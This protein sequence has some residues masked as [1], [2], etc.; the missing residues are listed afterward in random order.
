[1]S[2]RIRSNPYQVDQSATGVGKVV[3][4][5]KI[6]IRFSFG[7]ANEGALESGMKGV[8]CRGHEHVVT[9]FWSLTSGKIIID[10]DGREIHFSCQK[11]G[12]F[13]HSWSLKVNHTIEVIAHAAPAST[14]IDARPGW[15][16]YDLTIN[17]ISY[18][19]LPKIFELGNIP[20]Q[21]LPAMPCPYASPTGHWN[22]SLGQEAPDYAFCGSPGL[23]P[24]S[25][26]EG[27]LLKFSEPTPAPIQ[28]H[29][30][31]GLPPTPFPVQRAYDPSGSDT[32]PLAFATPLAGGQEAVPVL[33]TVPA[34]ISLP[35]S[36]NKVHAPSPLAIEDRR[37][38]GAMS[39]VER[40]LDSLVNLNDITSPVS[41]QIGRLT[42]MQS[43]DEKKKKTTSV[44]NVKPLATLQAEMKTSEH[45]K[46]NVMNTFNPS[47]MVQQQQAILVQS[48][49]AGYG[50]DQH[51]AMTPQTLGGMMPQSSILFSKSVSQARS[52]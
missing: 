16:Q 8:N 17:G 3:T 30:A 39:G 49:M 13:K 48:G 43:P 27:D 14:K 40:A 29:P 18:F 19:S 50:K 33:E 5:S 25:S 35:F 36:N 11:T 6:K 37:N 1:M 51:Q 24:P 10:C 21:Y 12:K 42:M 32:S 28:Q 38:P 2:Q 46:K 47:P 20:I 23:S 9:I 52:F 34:D 15:R 45:N 22:P 44:V 41:L 31:Y 26:A 4:A 7:F